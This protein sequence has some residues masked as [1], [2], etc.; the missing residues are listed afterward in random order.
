MIPDFH[1]GDFLLVT[2]GKF[3][4]RRGHCLKITDGMTA[5]AEPPNGGRV[6]PLAIS[7][8][9]F[10]GD[11][12]LSPST[13]RPSPLAAFASLLWPKQPDLAEY[14]L[15]VEPD[16]WKIMVGTRHIAHGGR[17]FGPDWWVPTILPEHRA[18]LQNLIHEQQSTPGTHHIGDAEGD[19]GGAP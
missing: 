7:D 13:R 3:L 12:P 14:A 4:G 16:G 19:A 17:A 1:P 5:L 8:L 15:I 9:C 10:D 2:A 11:P 18:L 6:G